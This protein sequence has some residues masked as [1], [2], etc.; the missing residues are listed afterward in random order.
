MKYSRRCVT[1]SKVTKNKIVP[2]K[3]TVE[4]VRGSI[5]KKQDGEPVD[6]SILIS[7]AIPNLKD[8]LTA[9]C[10]NSGL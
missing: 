4:R 10:Q 2:Q 5:E 3:A 8:I 9:L 6:F 7:E 1:D